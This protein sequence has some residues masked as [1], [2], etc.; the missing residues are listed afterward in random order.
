MSVLTVWDWGRRPGAATPS[1]ATLLHMV[2][3]PLGPQLGHSPPPRPSVRPVLSSALSYSY[4]KAESQDHQFPKQK[5]M[6][7]T[8]VLTK[9]Y[10]T[11]V[12][13]V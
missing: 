5:S 2:A 1:V 11:L 8:C 3:G 6:Y 7:S 9:L 4:F 10:L 13:F 12:F